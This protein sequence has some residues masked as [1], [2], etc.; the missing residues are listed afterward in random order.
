MIDLN[1]IEISNFLPHR[2]PFLM[3]DKVLELTDD[4][5]A[6]SFIIKKDC[7][8]VEHDLFSEVGLVENAAQTCSAIVGKSY[9]EED[10]VEGKGTS[11]IGFISAIKKIE[12]LEC[13]AVGQTIDTKASLKSRFDTDAYSIC[14]LEC[15]TYVAQ[16]K[17]GSFEMNLF[18]QE[19]KK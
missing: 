1:A 2:E 8:L 11:L 14:T 10:D 5:V 3:V 6:T 16:K 17:M 4:F 15:V 19:V 18:I 13:P 9:F 12:I 7:I